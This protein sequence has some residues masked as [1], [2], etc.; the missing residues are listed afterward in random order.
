MHTKI[1]TSYY[2]HDIVNLPQGNA[3]I[4]VELGVAKGIFSMRMIESGGLRTWG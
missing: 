4:G 2:R 1:L 3:N